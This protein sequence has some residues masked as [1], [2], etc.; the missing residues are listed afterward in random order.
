MEHR[1]NDRGEAKYWENKIFS[2][3]TL[4]TKIPPHLLAWNSNPDLRHERPA[5]NALWHGITFSFSQD[6]LK[7]VPSVIVVS[8][9]CVFPG[10]PDRHGWLNETTL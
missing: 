9:T 2:I 6:L 4:P 3:A 10:T 1:W 5:S 7:S 8:G